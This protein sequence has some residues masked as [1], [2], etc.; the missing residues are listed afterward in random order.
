[1]VRQNGGRKSRTGLGQV[2]LISKKNSLFPV[3]LSNPS[4]YPRLVL[5]K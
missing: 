4:S 3:Y 1:V 5:V 2:V